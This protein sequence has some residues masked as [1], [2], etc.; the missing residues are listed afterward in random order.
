MKTTIDQI[1]IAIF[2]IITII[3]FTPQIEKPSNYVNPEQELAFQL[4]SERVDDELRKIISRDVEKNIEL[5]VIQSLIEIAY[6]AYCYNP[7]YIEDSDLAKYI[8]TKVDDFN[9]LSDGGNEV[10][11]DGDIPDLSITRISSHIIGFGRYPQEGE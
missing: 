8:S 2:Y 3:V 1:I 7:P 4:E 5:D 9:N 10:F 11:F 6:E